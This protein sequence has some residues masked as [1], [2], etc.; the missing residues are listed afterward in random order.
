MG[1]NS[2]MPNV[3][4]RLKINKKKQGYLNNTKCD[5]NVKIAY[6]SKSRVDLWVN[7]YHMMLKHCIYVV[8]F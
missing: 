5:K 4:M 7:S 2:I 3:H 6:N 1:T 8:D